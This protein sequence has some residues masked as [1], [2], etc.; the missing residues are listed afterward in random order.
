MLILKSNRFLRIDSHSLLCTIYYWWCYRRFISTLRV[1]DFAVATLVLC[2][3]YTY[4]PVFIFG[5]LPFSR[6]LNL[7]YAPTFLFLL[8][9]FIP[10]ALSYE[11]D[12]CLNI[13]PFL[14]CIYEGEAMRIPQQ[15]KNFSQ[16]EVEL[17]QALLKK[18]GREWR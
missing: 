9:R 6:F 13:W 16:V 7:S 4:S 14:A 2:Y 5:A 3:F 12:C 8:L 11:V 15:W 10:C 17:K 18:Y 1:K